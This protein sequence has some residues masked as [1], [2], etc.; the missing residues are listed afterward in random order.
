MLVNLSLLN[1]RLEWTLLCACLLCTACTPNVTA[2][3]TA[4]VE[5]EDQSA[6]DLELTILTDRQ[7]RPQLPPALFG[8]NIHQWHFQDEL[9]LSR[10]RV[11]PHVIQELRK[12]PGAI[13][14]YP[15]GLLANVFDWP[16]ARGTQG[17]R[18]PQKLV[19]WSSAQKVSFGLE[20]Y[21]DFVMATGG[22]PWLV[23]NLV[24][25]HA[26]K[27][28]HEL[29]IEQV[30]AENAAV[31]AAAWKYLKKHNYLDA[32]EPLYVELGNELDRAKW[33]WPHQK[34]IE[35]SRATIEAIKAV[36]PNVRFVA[37]L[38][39]FDWRYRDAAR[40]GQYSR[41]PDFV[42]DVLQALPEVNDFSLHYYYDDPGL[43]HK[44]PKK[45]PWRLR[46]FQNTLAVAKQVR[47][48]IQL[49]V[50]EHAR[51][52]NLTQPKPM[53]RARVTSNFDAALS[54]ADFM[55]AM[56]AM[57]EVAGAALHGLNAG[58]WQVFDATAQH[59]DLR[60]RPTLPLMQMLADQ[61]GKPVLEHVLRDSKPPVY[62]D[63]Y[64]LRATVFDHGLSQVVW[65]VNRDELPRELKV[66]QQQG[67]QRTPCSVQMLRVMNRS[68]TQSARAR[69]VQ[70]VELPPRSISVLSACQ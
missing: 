66:V 58:P 1:V 24:G 20:E 48:N 12:L 19:K 21:L 3:P 23:A 13:Y 18:R 54:V 30:A 55:G 4:Q 16:N 53:S 57:P 49:W 38:R 25:W 42:S 46:Q 50:T 40:A 41:M 61:V 51:G 70:Q 6:R 35:R 31:V 43:E 9:T 47:P 14:R 63:Q 37:F 56:V 59:R 22:Q 44:N 8:F 65:I 64:T 60:P 67:N 26:D 36:V 39:D 68:G 69:A 27:I 62:A 34:Y 32:R 11:R 5:T 10:G 28:M 33:E 2:Q 7:I 15:G 45:I 29:P 52:V 17:N